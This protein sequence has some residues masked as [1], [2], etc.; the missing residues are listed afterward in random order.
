L[1]KIWKKNNF[2]EKVGNLGNSVFFSS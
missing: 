2:F 1:F